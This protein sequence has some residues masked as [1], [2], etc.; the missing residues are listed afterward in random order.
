ME[1]TMT[2]TDAAQM[3]SS[4]ILKSGVKKREREEVRE[5]LPV[6]GSV[7]LLERV[8][9]LKC[10]NAGP[11]LLEQFL[12]SLGGPG[13]STRSAPGLRDDILSSLQYVRLLNELQ[14]DLEQKGAML[15]SKTAGVTNASVSDG[16]LRDPSELRAII[17]AGVG[18]ADAEVQVLEA[19]YSKL[20]T[21]IADLDRK[22]RLCDA[23]LLAQGHIPGGHLPSAA[24]DGEDGEHG[25][26]SR[27]RQTADGAGDEG[28]G[29]DGDIAAMDEDG[30]DGARPSGWRSARSATTSSRK[31][32]ATPLA[33]DSRINFSGTIGVGFGKKQGSQSLLDIAIDPHEPT[34]CT[35]G[36]VAFGEMIACDNPAC[37]VEWFH[38]SCVGFKSYEKNVVKTWFCPLCR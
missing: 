2:G 30:G 29:E 11:A 8:D 26:S 7:E 10:M 25:S 14:A 32:G 9:I 5:K 23:I 15:C 35:C 12:H 37:T 20:D 21:V 34:Y 31:P 4:D 17:S 18:I 16:D 19:A 22:L 27:T 24:A 36:Q 3:L 28:E 1:T 6:R 33:S 13:V 38:Q